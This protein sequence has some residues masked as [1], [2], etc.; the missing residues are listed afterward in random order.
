MRKV[1]EPQT[2][3][4]KQLFRTLNLTFALVMRFPSYSW[5]CSI[6]TVMLK[7]EIK[8]LGL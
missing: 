8:F 5:A 3:L 7:P 2:E 6:F 4:G 1:M